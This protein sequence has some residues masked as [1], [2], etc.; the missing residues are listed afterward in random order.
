[1][2]WQ[3]LFP[4]QWHHLHGCESDLCLSG[5]HKGW[6]HNSLHLSLWE[7]ASLSPCLLLLLQFQVA[8]LM[9]P[10]RAARWPR[11]RLSSDVASNFTH[12]VR[13]TNSST[14]LWPQCPGRSWDPL[15]NTGN[16]SAP[17]QNWLYCGCNWTGQSQTNSYHHHENTTEMAVGERW[18]SD[19]GHNH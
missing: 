10:Q 17:R 4:S 1:M 6:V 18:T 19:L 9:L 12:W 16:I 8:P 13:E 5:S 7:K 11:H 3:D 15:Q 2:T 14:T